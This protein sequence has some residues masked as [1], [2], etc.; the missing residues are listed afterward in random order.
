MT[1]IKVYETSR[2]DEFFERSDNETFAEHGIPAH[3][4][5]VAF[6]YPD[7]HAVGDTWQKIDYDKM[8]RVTRTIYMTLWA[9]A[10]LPARPKVDKPL[11]AQLNQQRAAN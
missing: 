4:I 9:V 10:N 5:V 2:G 1:G 8:Q 7:Y 11:P 6:E 3:T